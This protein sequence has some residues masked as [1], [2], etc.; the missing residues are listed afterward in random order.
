MLDFLRKLERVARCNIIGIKISL[1]PRD[2][3]EM[4]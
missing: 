1:A 2:C 4:T 3:R